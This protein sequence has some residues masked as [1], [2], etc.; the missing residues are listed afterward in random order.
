MSDASDGAEPVADAAAAAD[1]DR[2]EYEEYDDDDEL[3]EPRG[4]SSSSPDKESAGFPRIRRKSVLPVDSQVL[5][6][7]VRHR[8]LEDVLAATPYDLTGQPQVGDES[9]EVEEGDEDDDDDDDD[10]DDE[11]S[12][13]ARIEQVN[14]AA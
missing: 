11:A 9:D 4:G 7:L 1:Y 13:S 8:S 14:L 3:T 6:L 5:N 10:D 2:D 12:L